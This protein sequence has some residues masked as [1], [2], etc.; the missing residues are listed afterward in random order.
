[1]FYHISYSFQK[2]I[3]MIVKGESIMTDRKIGNIE[4]IAL[5]LTVMIN[6]II[7]NL[8]KNIINSTSSGAIM[9]VIFISIL[10]IV[11]ALFIC[12]LLKNFPLLDIFDIAKFL[13]GKLLKTILRHFIFTILCFYNEHPS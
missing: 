12:K 6:H 3:N 5:I 10:A 9:N 13:G 1:M 8:P 4:A 11:I 2:Q 7:L